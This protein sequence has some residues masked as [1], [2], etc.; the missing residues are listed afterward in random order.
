VLCSHS[1]ADTRP[2]VKAA[3]TKED[4]KADYIRLKQWG[5]EADDLLAA[6]GREVL[7]FDDFL[8][9]T[10][11]HPLVA[12]GICLLR[13][14]DVEPSVRSVG[15][16]PATGTM[17]PSGSR[18]APPRSSPSPSS[19]E[20]VRPSW[21]PQDTDDDLGQHLSQVRQETTRGGGGGLLYATLN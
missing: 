18:R 8:H 9:C 14:S 13:R 11:A 15:G 4:W 16:A 5:R 1:W 20:V 17:S 7:T 19:P 21:T 2:E 10:A 12:I 3:F 6:C